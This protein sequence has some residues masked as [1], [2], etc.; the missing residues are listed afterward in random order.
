[1]LATYAQTD[2]DAR[3]TPPGRQQYTIPDRK[4]RIEGIPPYPIM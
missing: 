4:N 2:I 1:M 3:P